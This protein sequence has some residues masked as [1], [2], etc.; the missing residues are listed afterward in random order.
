MGRLV[1]DMLRLARLGQHPG[2]SAEPVDVTGVVAGCADRVAAEI[3]AAHG[4]AAHAAPA[5][6]HGLRITLALPV[7]LPRAVSASAA[8]SSMPG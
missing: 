6:P 7:H 5:S 1:D 3:A 8:Y 2:R 4:G